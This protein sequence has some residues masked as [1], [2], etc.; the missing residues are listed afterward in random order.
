MFTP[1]DE[2]K[3]IHTSLSAIVG[4][5][6]VYTA[7]TNASQYDLTYLPG[8]PSTFKIATPTDTYTRANMN[9]WIYFINTI[10]Q[11]ADALLKAI[12]ETGLKD[13]MAYNAKKLTHVGSASVDIANRASDRSTATTLLRSPP[14]VVDIPTTTTVGG[15]LG[16]STS[17]FP[18]APNCSQAGCIV[19][20]LPRGAG[21]IMRG[22]G[23]FT[24]QG[25]AVT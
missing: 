9:Y 11:D 17:A 15:G 22:G 3:G 20:A 6:P 25:P 4:G 7:Y 12:E 14:T 16:P 21:P 23:Q 8:V 24:L 5:Q 2:E 19:S 1:S 18:P 10:Y 13:Q